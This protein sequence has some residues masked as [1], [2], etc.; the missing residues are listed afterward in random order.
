MIYYISQQNYL[1]KK[2]TKKRQVYALKDLPKR[3]LA[4]NIFV[5]IF[6]LI[7]QYKMYEIT[8]NLSL[9]K[10]RQKNLF[11]LQK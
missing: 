3:T 7:S 9:Y 6:V 1:L 10:K 11:S 4:Q 8:T 5:N 2:G